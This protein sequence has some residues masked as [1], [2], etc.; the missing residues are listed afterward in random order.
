M[1]APNRGSGPGVTWKCEIDGQ[2]A[3]T[4]R[5]CATVWNGGLFDPPTAPGVVHSTGQL[6]A[7]SWDVTADVLAGQNQWLIKKRKE[8][9][10][11]PGGVRYHSRENGD[12]SRAPRLIL[13][14]R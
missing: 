9:A 7:V 2:I 6:A 3:N 12:P 10:F 4:V 11:Q 8:G 13:E 14:L 1:A 5:N